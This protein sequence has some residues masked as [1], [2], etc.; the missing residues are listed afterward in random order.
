[1]TLLIKEKRKSKNLSQVKLSH[2]LGI[3]PTTLNNWEQGVASPRTEKLPEIAAA[4][5]C[6]IDDLFPA[7]PGV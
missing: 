3:N 2:L 5:G 1:M 6:S 4:L 7:D